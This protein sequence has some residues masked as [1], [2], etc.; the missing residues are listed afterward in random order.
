MNPEGQ[1]TIEGL[2]T[3]YSQVEVIHRLSLTVGPGEVVGLAGRNGA[4]KTTT[5]RAVSGLLS[6]WSGQVLLGVE[7]LPA[8]PAVVAR[9]GVAHVPEG[10]GLM[11]SL[12]VIENLRVAAFAARQELT[13]ADLNRLVGVFPPLA[14]LLPR[15]AGSLSGGQQQIVALSRGLAAKPRILM[16]DEL[17]LGLAP[18]ITGDL[19]EALRRL[20]AEGNLGVLVIDQNLR[21]LRKYSDRL[22]WLNEG[23]SREID[24][25]ASNTE[26]MLESIYFD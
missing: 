5:L 16:V 26:K 14:A 2:R 22:Y 20:A 21:L 19:W 12:T 4:G 1:L 7:I 23:I 17:S 18:R 3:G 25:A 8:A 10:R 15:V 11:P 24:L 13:P 6:R 9:R